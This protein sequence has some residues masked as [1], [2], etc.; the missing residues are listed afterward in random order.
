MRDD[1]AGFTGNIPEHYDGGLGPIIF[2]H[3]AIDIARRAVAHG[4]SRVLETAAGTGIATRELRNVLPTEAELTATD[5]NQPMLDLAR[6]KFGDDEQVSFEAADATDL[7]FPDAT[8][9]AVVCQ[10]GVMFYPDKAKGHGEARRVLAPG[11]RYVFNVWDSHDYNPFA[12]IAH[13]VVNRFFPTEPPEFYRVPFSMHEIDPIKTSLI[14]EGFSDI[15][16]SV[17]AVEREIPDTDAFARG[18]VYGNPLIDQIQARGD[19]EPDRV[20]DAIAEQL[21]R[22][23]GQA[24]AP[25]PLQAIVFSATRT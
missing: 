6:A 8:F 11:G 3:Y 17:I 25:M 1:A 7:P 5:L 21:R 24:P 2:A 9:D 4:P 12:R 18:M 20:V 23:F 15:D 19:I 10:F 22:E 13:D 16:V 14:D